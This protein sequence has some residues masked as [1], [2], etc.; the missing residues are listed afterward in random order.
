MSDNMNN[1]VVALIAAV[2]GTLAALVA[3]ITLFQLNR[4]KEN[5]AKVEKNTNSITERLGKAKFSE[6]V[7]YGREQEQMRNVAA[8]EQ[9]SKGAELE[10]QKNIEIQ[11]AAN[12]IVKKESKKKEME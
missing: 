10:H 2:P 1:I 9:I 8:S 12:E 6:G 4:V 5:V 11:N 7:S 3:I